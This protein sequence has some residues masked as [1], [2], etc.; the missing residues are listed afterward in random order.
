[1]HQVI[2]LF[3]IFL[4]YNLFYTEHIVK[5]NV[6]P[7]DCL[8][9][10]FMKINQF[11][12]H[13]LSSRNTYGTGNKTYKNEI[14]IEELLKMMMDEVG[15]ENVTCEKENDKCVKSLIKSYGSKH[16]RD[17]NADG[18]INCDDLAILLYAGHQSPYPLTIRCTFFWN[19]YRRNVAFYKHSK[20]VDVN[21]MAIVAVSKKEEIPRKNV[22]FEMI[23]KPYDK[24]FFMCRNG[25]C[26]RDMFEDYIKPCDGKVQCNDL[27]DEQDCAECPEESIQCMVSGFSTCISSSDVCK[28]HPTS[29]SH[30]NGSSS[31]IDHCKIES[32]KEKFNECKVQL[33]QIFRKQF[34]EQEFEGIRTP[35]KS[36]RETLCRLH[37]YSSED[38]QS[39]Q[40]NP[41]LPTDF[42]HFKYINVNQSLCLDQVRLDFNFLNLTM[43]I[44]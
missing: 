30:R 33:N 32:W 29:C 28:Y 3:A 6:I 17:F 4:L 1:M 15:L 12:D 31:N 41:E 20:G 44:G 21:K 34:G 39:D 13:V 18:I 43:L 26:G 38:E 2:I 22:S 23:I 27:S 25:Q 37:G 35:E 24:D 11:E 40:F 5:E 42:F 16:I 19:I 8:K 36:Y 14:E 10:L 9:V 7:N